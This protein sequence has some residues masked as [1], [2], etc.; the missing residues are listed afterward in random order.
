LTKDAAKKIFSYLIKISILVLAFWFIYHQYLEKGDNLKSFELLIGRIDRQ[1]VE[2]TMS[3]ILLLMLLNW[4][5]ESFKWRYLTR[6]LEK[7]PA[8]GAIEAVFCGLTWAIFTPNRLGEY[9]GRVLFLPNRKR[10][11][12]VFAMAVGS[13][14]QNVVTNVVGLSAALWFIFSFYHLNIW[15]FLAI[16]VGAI[17]FMAFLL[18][19][20]FHIKWVVNLL[21]RIPYINK[22]HRFFDIIGRYTKAQL[23]T[24]MGFSLARFTVFS[25]QYYL[26]IHLLVPEI[27][28]FDM[29]MMVFVMFFVQSALPS[30]DLVD[31][32]VRNGTAAYLFGFIIH[33]PVAIMA[34]VSSIWFINIIIPAILGSV[35]VFKLHFFDRNV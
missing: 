22:F 5:L 14:G 4:T 29:M 21:D 13:F 18:I 16:G 30:L 23:I 31:V 20:F 12:G 34:A 33:Q 25:F 9:A 15:L 26:I 1:E 6:K 11:H 24:I 7:I 2:V 28:V 8:W 32:A 35:F 17:G 3:A 27:N 19:L 10:I